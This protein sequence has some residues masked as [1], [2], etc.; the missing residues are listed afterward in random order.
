MQVF[1][2]GAENGQE[3]C[4]IVEVDDRPA[5][6]NQQLPGSYHLSISSENLLV[7][8]FEVIAHQ[9]DKKQEIR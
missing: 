3:L 1:L 6:Y 7:M 8:L 2:S 5:R 4:R 9:T